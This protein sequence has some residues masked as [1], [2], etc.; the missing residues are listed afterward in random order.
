MPD[1]PVIG[2]HFKLAI[3]EQL[4]V[5]HSGKQETKQESSMKGATREY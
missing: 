4:F 3:L 2:I 1:L 5:F